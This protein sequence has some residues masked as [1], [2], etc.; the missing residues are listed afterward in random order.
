ML[1]IT[2][3]VEYIFC[4]CKDAQS[5]LQSINYKGLYRLL[6]FQY[7]WTCLAYILLVEKFLSDFADIIT[8]WVN[9]H[10]GESSVMCRIRNFGRWT[11]F[12]NK[13]RRKT[14]C[15]N[16]KN[17]IEKSAISSTRR[18]RFLAVGYF[19][20]CLL[21]EL[22]LHLLLRFVS[23]AVSDIHPDNAYE[24]TN[25]YTTSLTYW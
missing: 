7:L 5:I 13:R 21:F 20:F 18:G 25:P 3:Y 9:F 1:C 11:W 17:Y 16:S 24:L 2:I 8:L 23:D 14:T 19:L 22:L 15:C 12:E 10:F 4:K 6:Y